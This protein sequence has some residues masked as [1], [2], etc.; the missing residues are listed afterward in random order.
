MSNWAKF[1]GMVK[2]HKTL[3]AHQ[4]LFSYVS[5]VFRVNVWGANI[6]ESLCPVLL[7][8]QKLMSNNFWKRKDKIDLYY[9]LSAFAWGCKKKETSL[10]F[11][12]FIKWWWITMMMLFWGRHRKVIKEPITANNC[13]FPVSPCSEEERGKGKFI[14]RRESWIIDAKEKKELQILFCFGREFKAHQTLNNE[15]GWKV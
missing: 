12:S 5:S 9:V 4:K 6:H 8:F 11:L 3:D 13:R 15:L 1:S 7:I 2:G 10:Y 14:L